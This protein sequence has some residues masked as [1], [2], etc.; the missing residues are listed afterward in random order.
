MDIQKLSTNVNRKVGRS[1]K[2]IVIILCIATALAMLGTYMRESAATNVSNVKLYTSEVETSMGEKMSFIDT[3]A[4]G[5]TSGSVTGDYYDYVDT[6]VAMYDD[7]SAVYVVLYDGN[8]TYEDGYT[9][10]MSGG[11]IP[12]ETFV[13]SS[14]AWFTGAMSQEGTYISEPYVDEQSGGICI[15]LAKAI[16]KDGKTIGVA[17]LDMYMDD[18]VSLIESSYHDGNYVF[19]VS[20]EGTILTHPNDAFALSASASTK[21]SDALK[22]RYMKAYN[23]DLKTSTIMDYA[24]GLKNV[25]CYDSQL[26]GWSILSVTSLK[27]IIFIICEMAIL[28][29]VLAILISKLAT[30]GLAKEIS[31]MFAP[32]EDLTS[33]VR[34]ITDGE[35]EYEF[36]VDEQSEEV[37]RLSTALNDTMHGLR[38]YIQQIT[39]TVTAI[40]EKDLSFSVNG[41]YNG[42][43]SK[44]RDALTDIINVLNQ[45]FAEINE[46]ARTVL[47][48]SGNL[49]ETSEAVADSATQQ[50]HAVQD[51]SKEMGTLTENMAKIAEIAERIKSNTAVTNAGLATGS[52]EMD[53]LVGAMDEI[54]NC[55]N[56]IS[57]FV[58]EINNIASQTN[59]LSLNASIEAARAGE[60]GRGFAVVAGEISSLADTS[61]AASSKISETINRTQVAVN[62]GRDMV[63]RT[64]KT[65]D[66][67]VANSVA[68]DEMVNEIV[69][70]VDTQKSSTTHISENLKEISQMVETNAASAEENSAISSQLGDCAKSLMDTIGEFRLR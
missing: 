52:K 19:L 31:P 35:L 17:G 6:M 3:V 61:S 5:V 30:K 54:G 18:L 41:D 32:L 26:T 21:I 15:T 64:A 55:F 70:F 37:N 45:S 25:L 42:D 9:T 65:I 28:A 14:R 59:L 39:D 20:G 53:E 40:S 43:Y 48:F 1:V 62:K 22:G 67:S 4:A 63:G 47:E 69:G 27:V 57:E 11:W 51:A 36:D 12:P 56:E 34:S 33:N 10:Y 38:Q 23:K 13:V 29:V 7:V 60:V 66:D 58:D 50:A 49:A 16:Y 24:G 8:K 46:Q 44:I 2:W 68:S